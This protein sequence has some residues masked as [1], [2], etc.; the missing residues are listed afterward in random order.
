LACDYQDFEII[1]IDQ[2]SNDDTKNTVDEF[3]KDTRIR[4]FRTDTPGLGRARTYGIAVARSEYCCFTDDDCEVS[5]DWLGT[6]AKV[7]S[8]NPRAA[9]AYCSVIAGPHDA[10]KGFVP[11]YIPT[12]ETVVANIPG[13]CK[14]RGIGAGLS[15]RKSIS[16]RIGGFDATLGAGSRF[17]SCEDGDFSVRALLAGYQIVETNKTSVLHHGFRTFEQGRKLSERDWF[18]IGS[19]YS[20]PLKAGRF[21]FAIVPLY[22]FFVVA[23][24]PPINDLFH[25]RRPRG[26]TRPIFFLK[27]FF[28]CLTYPV[29]KKT[30][31]FGF[32]QF[33]LSDESNRVQLNE[34]V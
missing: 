10:T 19:S 25:L 33:S 15:V 31:L 16:D 1:V 26:L 18:G 3:L 32:K 29:D 13:K 5:A 22:E 34:T 11:A 12:H 7:L 2:S 17:F 9:A 6:M 27:G 21:N 28:T 4:Y 23:M 24:W 8:E 14:A 20:K 30:L